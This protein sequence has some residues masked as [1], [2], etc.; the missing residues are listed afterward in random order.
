MKIKFKKAHPDV[1]TPTKGTSGSACWDLYVKGYHSINND[2]VEYETGISVEIPEGYVGLLFPRSSIKDKDLTLSNSVGVIDSDYRGTIK[3]F[4]CRKGMHRYYR[5]GERFLQLMIIP[6]PSI[7]LEEV[8][9]LSETI[10][11]SGGF[12]STG[13]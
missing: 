12:G 9:E 10:R 4:F 2:I 8:D 13:R 7:E 3:A 11:G 1:I 5:I 6:I